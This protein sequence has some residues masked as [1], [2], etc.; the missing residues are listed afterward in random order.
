MLAW[1]SRDLL[2]FVVLVRIKLLA[3]H[4][5]KLTLL[6]LVCALTETIRYVALR[7]RV[8]TTSTALILLVVDMLLFVR[9]WFFTRIP[10]YSMSR[11]VLVAQWYFNDS[12]ITSSPTVFTVDALLY[13]VRVDM[14]YPQ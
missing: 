10:L 7:V 5:V 13:L 8:K 2:S 9:L 3:S 11:P 1:V 4:A 12:S 14:T 6:S